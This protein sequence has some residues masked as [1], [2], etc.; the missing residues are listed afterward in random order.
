MGLAAVQ[1]RPVH[2]AG[3]RI[4]AA[5]PAEQGL[6]RGRDQVGRPGQGDV[7][8]ELG[9]GHADP[10]AGGGEIALGLAHVGAP[11]QEVGRQAGGDRRR[12]GGDRRRLRQLGR[13]I[14]GRLAQQDAQGMDLD[15]CVRLQSRQARLGV[16]DLV[17]LALGVEAGGDARPAPVVDQGE[18]ALLARDLGLVD[19]DAALVGAQGEIGAGH[20]GGEGDF[21]VAAAPEGRF[22]RGP[23]GLDRPAGPAE[24]VDLPGGVEAQLVEADPAAGQGEGRRGRSRGSAALA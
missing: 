18:Q 23:G 10:G 6:Q 7:R 19:G 14:L 12:R 1:Q 20:L 3:D 17:G 4:L 22:R 16:G 24:H 13:Q 11:G 9:G 21:G 8:I 15:R 2:R 5:G